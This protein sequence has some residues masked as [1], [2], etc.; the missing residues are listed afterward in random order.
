MFIS[1][2]FFASEDIKPD[3]YLSKILKSQNINQYKIIKK[4]IDA[5]NKTRIV[6]EYQLK[7]NDEDINKIINLNINE[8]NR[9]KIQSI[10][11]IDEKKDFSDLGNLLDS[12]S[13][14]TNISESQ[15]SLYK[16]LKDTKEDLKDSKDSKESKK[17]SKNKSQ[18][19]I[20][21]FG[22]AGIFCA[23]ALVENNFAP[24]I[25]EM[26]EKVEER[27][28]T[29]DKYIKEKIF[30][31]YSNINFGEGG[32]GTY[33]D[34]KL[35]TRS[36]NEINRKI[37]EIFKF[38]GAP[39]SIIY[40]ANPHIGSDNL[41]KIIPAIRTFLLEKGVEFLFNTKLIDIKKVEN[42]PD[43]NG[44]WLLSL[45]DTKDNSS[46]QL[47]T[48][49]VILAT[50]HSCRDIYRILYKIGAKLEAKP[51][52]LGFR[53]EHTRELID[54]N[55]YGRFYKV[56][57]AANY[58]LLYKGK[59]SNIYS[60]C[61]CPGGVVL[62]SNSEENEV[63]TNGASRYNRDG[64][65]SNAAIVSSFSN[66]QGKE[67]I[68]GLTKDFTK[69]LHY[70]SLINKPLIIRPLKFEVGLVS[71]IVLNLYSA[72]DNFELELEN[73]GQAETEYAKK[74]NCLDW[75]VNLI[76]QQIFEKIAFYM[77]EQDFSAPFESI[78]DFYKNPDKSYFDYQ[79]NYSDKIYNKISNE[80]KYNKDENK[81]KKDEKKEEIDST[82]PFGVYKADLLKLFPQSIEDDFLLAIKYFD[83]IIPGFIKNG[84][85]V[86]YETRTSSVIKVIRSDDGMVM[87]GIYMAGEGSGYCGGITTSAV[88]GYKIGSLLAKKMQ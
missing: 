18:P 35:F 84:I 76:V 39:E 45:L 65:N 50:G 16:D 17:N 4:S 37:I 38:F 62:P 10:K 56:L 19:V 21:G 80:K 43:F 33:S 6:L 42:E 49:F 66:S 81:S 68:E 77:G 61:M 44:K 75:E 13:L 29:I 25:I 88:D 72:S 57:P 5:R 46:K 20:V 64:Q 51:F 40:D 85:A 26:G 22:P 78:S 7:L 69:R 1:L 12:K 87:D 54:K 71:K 28:K 32:A 70:F 60:F 23:L 47:K 59:C 24:I 15:S 41:N 14:L 48:D 83:R 82:Y 11:K 27:N 79:M 31:S 67:F 55:Q 30:D 8:R 73:R 3:E 63:V 52:A 53:V 34:G 74:I 9:L 36:R 58:K 2:R 86:G